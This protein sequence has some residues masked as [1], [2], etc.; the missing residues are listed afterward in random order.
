M[1]AKM[2]A[3]RKPRKSIFVRLL[4]IGVSVYMIATLASLW[5]TLDES[6]RELASLQQEY[7]SQQAHIDE[8]RAVLEDGSQTAL[9]EKAARE[10]LGYVYA[11]EEVYIDVS[12]K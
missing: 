9:I 6:R 1:P 4:V 8:L 10:R 3:K 7:D 5:N 12:G 11:D 2:Q